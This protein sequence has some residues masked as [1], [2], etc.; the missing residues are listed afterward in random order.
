MTNP[1]RVARAIDNASLAADL[2]R[3]RIPKTEAALNM[4][5]A[6][7]NGSAERVAGGDISKPVEA[8]V[9][10]RQ[11]VWDETWTE[12]HEHIEEATR[13]LHRALRTLGNRIAQ[14]EEGKV[15]ER[16]NITHCQACERVVANTPNDRLR[17]GYCAACN[18]AWERQGRPD[19]PGFERSRRGID[20]NPRLVTLNIAGVDHQLTQEQAE[21]LGPNPTDETIAAI[22]QEITG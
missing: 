7:G 16:T 22:K 13:A 18:R 10:T 5:I 1:R 2:I 14:A 4:L 19:R 6:T 17:G 21:R 12:A 9:M 11:A 20:T 15:E 8:A 3:T